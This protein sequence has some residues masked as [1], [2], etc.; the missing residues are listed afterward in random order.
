MYFEDGPQVTFYQMVSYYK[1]HN[2]LYLVHWLLYPIIGLFLQTHF[3][4]CS[5][6]NPDYKGINCDVFESLHPMTI[7]LSVLV[8]IEMLNAL[9]RSGLLM[10]KQYNLFFSLAKIS[11]YIDSLSENQSLLKMPPWKNRWLIAAIALSMF[12]HVLILYIPL[13]AVSQVILDQWLH[14][15]FFIQFPKCCQINNSF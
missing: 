7:A 14:C 3:S 1:T 12:Q 8:T 5:A 10:I 9:N 4:K 11:F 6:D 13:L 2:F 15:S